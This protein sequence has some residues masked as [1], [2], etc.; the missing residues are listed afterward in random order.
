ME[1]FT[2]QIR[3]ICIKLRE[4]GKADRKF[5]V[6]GADKH[7]Y[8]LYKPLKPI[9]VAE[10]EAQYEI[11]LPESFKA[12]LLYIG[13]GGP[14]YMESAGP[15]YGIYP[16]G[17]NVDELTGTPKQHL[18]LPVAIF[19]GMNGDDWKALTKDIDECADDISDEDFETLL[20][21]VY[22]G[23]LP[24]GSQGCSYLHALLLNGPHA[25][26]VVNVDIDRQKP[27]FTYEA[28]FLDWYERWLDE[29]ISGDLRQ[30]SASWFGYSM[31]GTAGSLVEKFYHF[32]NPDE[33]EACLEGLLQKHQLEP[34]VLQIVEKECREGAER[35][36]KLWLQILTKADYARAKPYLAAYVDTDLLAVFSFVYWYAKKHGADWYQTIV[37][38]IHRINDAETFRFCTYLLREM[39]AGYGELIAPFTQHPVADIRVTAF[40]TL[41]QLPQKTQYLDLFIAGLNDEA[42]KVVRT[43]LQALDGV[44]NKRL[45][46]PYKSL[47]E[48]FPVEQDYI[49]SNLHQQLRKM[50]ITAAEL[51]KME[52]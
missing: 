16:L 31:G 24:L 18:K 21:H 17:N 49:L 41:G 11:T 36:R 25:G 22:G 50:N 23:I 48:R 20:G 28:N 9:Q 43:T 44:N 10:F 40:Y 2:E 47:L 1:Q 4:A 51:R 45:L 8:K 13:N 52:G 27:V 33:K 30:D 5:K 35:Y 37:Q 46:L 38:H 29:V 42:T 3:R 19:P 34:V 26:K 14:S 6:F 32:T 15:F 7:K 12:F 39:R